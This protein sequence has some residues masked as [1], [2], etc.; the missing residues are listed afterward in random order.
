MKHQ[1]ITHTPEKWAQKTDIIRY[2]QRQDQSC[3]YLEV[4]FDKIEDRIVEHKSELPERIAEDEL[5][6]IL[7]IQAVSYLRGHDRYA[8]LKE[9]SGENNRPFRGVWT[10]FYDDAIN[11]ADKVFEFIYHN[12]EKSQSSQ[13]IIDVIQSEDDLIHAIWRY[14][15]VKSA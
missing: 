4:L 2:G 7:S 14:K 1:L 3:T 9:Y 8:V 5:L 15:D 11:N 13:R 6:T 10:K 12:F